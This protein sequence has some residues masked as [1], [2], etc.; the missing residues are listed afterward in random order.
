[1]IYLHYVP[2]FQIM[3]ARMP[4][5]WQGVV[6]AM[7]DMSEQ[8]AALFRVLWSKYTLHFIFNN[9]NT[10]IIKLYFTSVILKHGL[11]IFNTN[12]IIWSVNKIT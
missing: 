11:A 12:L 4:D 10:S 1:M 5:N 2:L 7:D 6:P 3:A 9:I 8:Q